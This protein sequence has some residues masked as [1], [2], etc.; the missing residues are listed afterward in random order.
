[1]TYTL[2]PFVRMEIPSAFSNKLTAFTASGPLPVILYTYVVSSVTAVRATCSLVGWV[3]RMQHPILG[4]LE[5]EARPIRPL[6]M[7]P[8]YKMERILYP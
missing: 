1:M 6:Q 7:Q 3:L 8:I 4:I 2:Q 5:M